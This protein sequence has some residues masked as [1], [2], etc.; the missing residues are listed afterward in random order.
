MNK[1][2][3]SHTTGAAPEMTFE[4]WRAYIKIESFKLNNINY[5]Q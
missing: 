1:L 3:I 5:R 4:E 2:A